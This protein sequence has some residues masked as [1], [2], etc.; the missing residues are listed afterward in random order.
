VSSQSDRDDDQ[1]FGSGAEVPHR[2]CAGRP[3]LHQ[4]IRHGGHHERNVNVSR[5][6]HRLAQ[7][8]K[9][10]GLSQE[11]LAEVMG[12]DRST[13]VRWERADTEPQPWHRPKLARALEVS[14][15]ELAVL[16]ADIGEVPPA[17]PGPTLVPASLIPVNDLAA[18]QSLRTA[19]SQLGGGYLYATVASYLQH[20]VGPRLLA[21]G[22]VDGE[23][24]SVFMAAAA[25]TEMAGWMAHDA[26]RDTLAER[27]FRRA[28]SLAHAG[29][30]HQLGAHIF[31]SLS[32]L[33]HHTGQP[34][35]AV[36]YA[37]EGHKR[38]GSGTPLPA[39]E[40][41]LLAMQARGYAA[42]GEDAACDQ[43]LRKAERVLSGGPDETPSPWVSPFDDASLAAEAARCFHRLRR[44]DAARRQAEHVVELRPRRRA[45]SRAFAQL[46]LVSTLI[47]EGRPDEACVVAAE[48]LEATRNLGSYLVVQQL[49]ES[50]RLLSPFRRSHDVAEFLDILNAELRERR[51]LADWLS[52]IDAGRPTVAP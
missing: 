50:A 2:H 48:V 20:N 40:A 39:A 25:M 5:K 38:L 36:A 11:G 3:G 33:A 31:G 10:V 44:Y 35:Q 9:A 42:L 6:R 15:E 51:W 1:H 28:L 52:P 30:D 32:H 8:R 16:L 4:W 49:E 24:E 7:R 43:Q 13:V 45:R 26:G 37:V 34:K 12:V 41:R 18:M 23:E 21:G 27:H 22:L 29:Q 47:A 46:I 19:D 14:V 17:I